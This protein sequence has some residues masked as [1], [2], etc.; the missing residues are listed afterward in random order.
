MRFCVRHLY[1]NFKKKF[2]GLLLKQQLWACARATTVEE[3]KRR[4]LELK[5]NS[6]EAFDWLSEK[7]PSEWTKSHFRTQPKCDMLLNNLCESFNAVIL[8]GRDKPIITLLEYIRFWLMDRMRKQRESVSKWH[9]PVG[10]RLFDILQ[11]NRK[12]ALKFQCTKAAGGLFQ[13]TVA[14]GNAKAT[15]L[16][17][18]SCSCRSYDPTGIPC[19]HALACI[20]YS[21]LNEYDYV[22]EC[23]KIETFANQYAGFITPMPGPE[24]WHDKGQNPIL[25]PP[26]YAMPGRPK[27]SRKREVN[28][29][30]PG[31]SKM[32]RFG[33]SNKCS[34]CH[35]KGHVRTTCPKPV[36]EQV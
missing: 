19:G 10:K 5:A 23:Y 28:E 29:P 22:A 7:A 36:Q 2:P 27:K 15:N 33:Q 1:A 24:H 8:E 26:E 35:E 31:S 6:A 4:M 21:N 32:R 16:E 20:Y 30:P 25:P 18:R 34:N 12:V 11:N 14:S 3:F 17:T 9:Y 13:V